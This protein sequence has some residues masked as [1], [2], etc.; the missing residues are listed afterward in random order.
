MDRDTALGV[1]ANV[2]DMLA[3]F[4]PVENSVSN[5]EDRLEESFDAKDTLSDRLGKV[6]IIKGRSRS[7]ITTL[8]GLL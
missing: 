1:K 6:G 5:L 8:V 7:P 3:G 4:G 2:D